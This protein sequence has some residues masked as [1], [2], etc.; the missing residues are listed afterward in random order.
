[1]LAASPVRHSASRSV[2]VEN[3]QPQR[4]WEA[5]PQIEAISPEQAT[6][7]AVFRRA[8][9]EGDRVPE[10]GLQVVEGGRMGTRGLNVALARRVS[11]P[12]G[13]VWVT[14]G[15]GHIALIVPGGATGNPTWH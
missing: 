3:Q 2:P 7:F 8:Q 6:S 11:T 4:D 9:R 12:A 14:P 15:N 1:M 13:D 10:D 5:R